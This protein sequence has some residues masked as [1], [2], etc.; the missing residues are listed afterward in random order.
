MSARGAWLAVGVLAGCGA[1]SPVW[2][3][4]SAFTPA[5]PKSQRVIGPPGLYVVSGK[6]DSTVNV[7]RLPDANNRGPFCYVKPSF[8]AGSAAGI[9]I[10]PKGH[11]W[12]PQG[13]VSGATVTEYGGRCGASGRGA[14][15]LRTLNDPDG[16]PQRV[17]FD[18]GG[19]V[20]VSNVSGV[21][22]CN[23]GYNYCA[24]NIAVY[25]RGKAIPTAVLEPPDA[26]D[27]PYVYGVAVD[28]GGDV[29]MSYGF[30]GTS[31]VA[32]FPAGSK[33]PQ[34]LSLE[35]LEFPL[36]LTI[37]AEED[38]VATDYAASKI[39]V[40]APPYS[41]SPIHTIS[42]ARPGAY[43]ALDKKNNVIYL[44]TGVGGGVLAFAYPS[45]KFLYEV[46]A[47]LSPSEGAGGIAIDP[48]APN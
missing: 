14:Q 26:S 48:A 27:D 34:V 36:D 6:N 1:A 10:D 11:L 9:A 29:F 35:D 46:T 19:A 8:R 32:E 13:A 41:G 12:F 20:Y 22:S 25:P 42:F 40:Y 37:D 44:S 38:L 21:G 15:L 45:G 30:P 31:Q 43:L 24:G 18:D 33:T 47:G 7:Y 5:P 28:A 4:Q 17:A 2:A 3:P 39:Q 23:H 16:Q